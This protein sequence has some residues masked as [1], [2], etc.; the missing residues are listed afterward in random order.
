M[1][2]NDAQTTLK[3]RSNDAQ[4]TLKWCSN[5]PGYILIKRDAQSLQQI[6]M[7]PLI[8][9]AKMIRYVTPKNVLYVMEVTAKKSKPKM[10][11]QLL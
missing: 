3:R 8:W 5:D 4:K 2:S 9:Y 1:G 11:P 7:L 10:S 6:M